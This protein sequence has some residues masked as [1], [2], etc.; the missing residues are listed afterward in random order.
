MWVIEWAATIAGDY[1]LVVN[2]DGQQVAGP[3]DLPVQPPE[4]TREQ[5]TFLAYLI[6]LVASLSSLALRY[7]TQQHHLYRVVDKF[8]LYLVDLRHV[9]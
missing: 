1:T 6:N 2:V 9:V 4:L 3:Y 5:S 8:V 7:P